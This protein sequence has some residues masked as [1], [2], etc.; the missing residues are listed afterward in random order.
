M[1]SAENNEELCDSLF[2]PDVDLSKC[3]QGF[4]NLVD[5]IREDS[6]LRVSEKMR[7]ELQEAYNN[8]LNKN[9]QLVADVIN[10]L[11]ARYR[12]DANFCRAV[13][14]ILEEEGALTEE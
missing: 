6:V 11:D 8:V 1:A 7:R 9:P 5:L 12:N 3:E 13:Q 14:Y 4:V 10:K 2:D